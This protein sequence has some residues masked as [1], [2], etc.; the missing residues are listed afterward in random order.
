MTDDSRDASNSGLNITWK[1]DL[2]RPD[3]FFSVYIAK[4]G[5]G[6]ISFTSPELN[7]CRSLK[8][9]EIERLKRL[10]RR[11]RPQVIPQSFYEEVV[12]VTQPDIRNE[13]EFSSGSWS[14]KFRWSG[15]DELYEEN[16]L[17][18]LK[19]IGDWIRKAFPVELMGFTYTEHR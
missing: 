19:N 2:S 14:A 7:C 3:C 17:N 10:L 1:F 4:N 12:W 6:L 11:I 8:E 9:N 13:I 5:E 18:T 15:S 16:N